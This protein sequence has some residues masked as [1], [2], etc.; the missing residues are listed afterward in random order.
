MLAVGEEGCGAIL[1]LC[2]AA[3]PENKRTVVSTA[4]SGDGNED[5]LGWQRAG[6]THVACGRVGWIRASDE[7]HETRR[8]A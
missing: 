4:R 6:G 7:G 2:S 3:T 1:P 8:N 5:L